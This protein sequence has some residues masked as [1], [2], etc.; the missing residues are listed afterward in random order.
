MHDNANLVVKKSQIKFSDSRPNA[1]AVMVMI[2]P[3]KFLTLPKNIQHVLNE[4]GKILTSIVPRG[5]G[6]VV[7]H[8]ETKE[9]WRAHYDE[10]LSTKRCLECGIEIE[11]R[12][13]RV[14]SLGPSHLE[15]SLYIHFCEVHPS[16]GA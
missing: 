4:S 15:P 13:V 12:V 1:Q 11:G 3:H 9:I 2:D 10:P 8:C 7:L 16:E 5:M 6:V 14:T